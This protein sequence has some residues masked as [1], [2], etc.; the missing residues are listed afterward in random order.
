MGGTPA[1]AS[2]N[3]PV[4]KVGDFLIRMVQGFGG[5]HVKGFDER[6]GVFGIE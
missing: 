1:S 2:A 3:I 4:I 6:G 5:F